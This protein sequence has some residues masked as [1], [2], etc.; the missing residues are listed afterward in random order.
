MK[1]SNDFIRH[2]SNSRVPE[3]HM[4]EQAQVDED[5]FSNENSNFEIDYDVKLNRFSL[6]D[7]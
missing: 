6:G 1:N 4:I 3:S 2:D 5:D 7:E